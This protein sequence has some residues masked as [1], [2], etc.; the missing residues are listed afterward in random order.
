MKLNKYDTDGITRLGENKFSLNDCKKICR[1]LISNGVINKQGKF[2]KNLFKDRYEQYINFEMPSR[3]IL[4]ETNNH[5]SSYD[6]IDFKEF[7]GNKKII[8]DTIGN[9]RKTVGKSTLINFK[10]ELKSQICD[11]ISKRIEKLIDNIFD[12]GKYF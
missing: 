4:T 3:N 7:S 2:D 5:V 9:L 8:I 1:I 6:E 10:K 12:F 11:S